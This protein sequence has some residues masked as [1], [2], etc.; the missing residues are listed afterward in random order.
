MSGDAPCREPCPRCRRTRP[1]A[2]TP[3]TPGVVSSAFGNPAHDGRIGSRFFGPMSV[4]E[5]QA[6]ARGRLVVEEAHLLGDEVRRVHTTRYESRFTHADLAARNVIVRGGGGDVAAII[7]WAYAGWYPEYCEFTKAHYVILED[8]WEG[9]VRGALP[10]YEEELEAERILWERLPEPGTAMTSYRDGVVREHPGS[11]PSAAWL[12]ARSEL[13][14]EDLW[15]LTM[16]LY[17]KLFAR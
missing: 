8:E 12:E 5:F 16:K 10:C 11:Y 2:L 9:N 15:S 7:D 6:Q 13:Q 4:A 3:P 1:R 17:P 14:R